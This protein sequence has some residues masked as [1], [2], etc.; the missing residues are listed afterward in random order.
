MDYTALDGYLRKENLCRIESKTDSLEF[1]SA[2][3]FERLLESLKNTIMHENVNIKIYWIDRNDKVNA[4]V[5]RLGDTYYIG[6]FSGVTSA[7]RDHFEAY[8]RDLEE[9]FD[10]FVLP[11]RDMYIDFKYDEAESTKSKMCNYLMT[12]ALAYLV[13]HE[14]GHILCGHCRKEDVFFY[15]NENVYRIQGYKAQA[16]EMLADFY[17]IANSY[18]LFLSTFIKNPNNVGPFSLLYLLAAY[19]VFWIFKFDKKTLLESDCSTMSHPHSQVRFWY[20]VEFLENEL[21]HSI[22]MF[23]KH[24]IIYAKDDAYRTIFEAVLEDYFTVLSHTKIDFMYDEV[25]VKM[26]DKEVK[27]IRDEVESVVKLYQNQAY[28]LPRF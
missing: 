17:G 3:F 19:S 9:R 12:F 24:K 26:C 6:L 4:N 20:F 14:F 16:K 22:E 2:S 11:S 5:I 10:W 27:N 15:E 1:E 28:V 8:Y 25:T 23:K 21:K 13:M 18:N 7:L